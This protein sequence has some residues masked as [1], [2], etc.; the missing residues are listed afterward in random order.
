MKKG[1]REAAD[2]Q[3]EATVTVIEAKQTARSVLLLGQLGAGGEVIPYPYEIRGGPGETLHGIVAGYIRPQAVR[4]APASGSV[5]VI[6]GFTL[7][8]VYT[9]GTGGSGCR[10]LA[11]P[12]STEL[13]FSLRTGPD[14]TGQQVFAQA[15]NWQC[16]LRQLPGNRIGASVTADIKVITGRHAT[17]TLLPARI[18][19]SG[20]ERDKSTVPAAAL[21][22]T[23]SLPA[24]ILAAIAAAFRSAVVRP[25]GHGRRAEEKQVATKERRLGEMRN[26]KRDLG[27]RAKPEEYRVFVQNNSAKKLAADLS[28]YEQELSFLREQNARLR[29]QLEHKQRECAELT[30]ALEDAELARI[31][32]RERAK[33]LEA[34]AAERDKSFFGQLRRLVGSR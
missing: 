5:R 27:L 22:G 23:G 6:V 26:R 21:S 14:A 20:R 11:E 1:V 13:A 30:K 12:A 16:D 4:A 19:R 7:I 25:T 3:I 24:E 28:S 18:G 9:V 8:I 17:I 15:G 31:A 10:L 32:A 29:Q 2:V 33:E 34:V